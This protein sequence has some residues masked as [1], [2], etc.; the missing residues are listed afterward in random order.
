[1]M[2]FTTWQKLHESFLSMKHPQAMALQKDSPSDDD[3]S[4]IQDMDMPKDD[5]MGDEDDMDGDMDSDDMD[6]DDDDDMGDE[7]GMD[8][9]MDS[10]DDSDDMGSDVSLGGDADDDM[11][12]MGNN[13]PDE[14]QNKIHKSNMKFKMGEEKKWESSFTEYTPFKEPPRLGTP[15]YAADFDKSL[16]RQYGKPGERFDDGMAVGEDVLFNPPTDNSSA[17][18]TAEEEK[19]PSISSWD[20]N[21]EEFLDWEKDF[22]K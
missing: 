11:P 14:L 19:K 17:F 13:P 18:F 7:D 6:M 22:N 20:N 2:K 4:D 12:D 21:W 1:M 15:E 9:D 16:E 3:A 10:D 8:G 5:D